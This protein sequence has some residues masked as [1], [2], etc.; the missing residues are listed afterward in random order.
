M[1]NESHEKQKKKL[2]LIR[3]YRWQMGTNERGSS[4][5]L[6]S[7]ALTSRRCFETLDGN[8]RRERKTVAETFNFF[9]SFFL[10]SNTL[11]CLLT[12]TRYCALSKLEYTNRLISTRPS[13]L[14][15]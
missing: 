3:Y 7:A 1:T 9:S 8:A 12:L 6:V 13:I 2:E 15:E 5:L 11:N 4:R 14:I 10:R